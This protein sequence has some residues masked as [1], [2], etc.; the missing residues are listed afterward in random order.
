METTF[1]SIEAPNYDQ[2]PFFSSVFRC[3]I[4]IGSF[5]IFT[6]PFNRSKQLVGRIVEARKSVEEDQE[7]DHI[8]TVNVFL[9]FDKWPNN[10]TLY[11]IKVLVKVYKK[12]TSHPRRLPTFILI[13]LAFAFNTFELTTRGAILQVIENVFVCRCCYDKF[14]RVPPASQGGFYLIHK[15]KQCFFSPNSAP[16]ISL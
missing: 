1:S 11:P 13:D 12:P 6:T 5:F 9:S 16:Q 4:A 7:E 15:Q 10:E 2:K 8:L 14:V 3:S